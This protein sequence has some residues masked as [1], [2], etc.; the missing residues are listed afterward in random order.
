MLLP[1]HLATPHW[2]LRTLGEDSPEINR[3]LDVHEDEMVDGMDDLFK[4]FY[5][6]KAGPFPDTDWHRNQ[7]LGVPICEQGDPRGYVVKQDGE[8]GD[9]R[10]WVLLAQFEFDGLLEWGGGTIY[11]LIE[12]SKLAAQD[13]S[14]VRAAYQ[15]T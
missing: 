13:F 15:T 2:A 1:A 7:M 12:K 3:F 14:D 9:L 10:D 4:K 8:M 11:F 5:W 6:G